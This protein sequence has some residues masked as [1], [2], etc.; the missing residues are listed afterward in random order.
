MIFQI[1]LLIVLI[2]LFGYLL[3]SRGSSKVRAYKK[4]FLVVVMIGAVVAVLYPG[5]TS[6]IAKIVGVGRG[7]DLVFYVTTIVVLFTLLND[8]VK[9]KEEDRRTV[10][11][12]RRVA[13]LEE[14]LKN[15]R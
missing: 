6:N 11:L 9:D 8:Y 2:L 10:K 7:A 4:L 15:N 3:R 1:L 12:A 5:V 14:Q 13:L